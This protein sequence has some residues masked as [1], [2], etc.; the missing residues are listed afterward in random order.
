RVMACGTT[1]LVDDAGR[2]VGVLLCAQDIS[3]RKRVEE[4]LRESEAGLRAV[5]DEAP[6]VL[7]ALDRTGT[8]TFS[9]GKGLA[10]LGLE[11]GQRVGEPIGDLLAQTFAPAKAYFDRA[12]A[13]EPVAWT[14]SFGDAP[15]ECQLMPV[16]DGRSDPAGIIGRAAGVPGRRPAEAARL[17]PGRRF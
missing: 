5:I 6:V 4:A 16:A 12:F 9:R 11:P 10:R 13:G 2:A 17:G 15:F 14:G 1:R 8:L 3:E 7:F